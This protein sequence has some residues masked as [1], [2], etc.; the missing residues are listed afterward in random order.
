MKKKLVGIALFVFVAFM[1]QG[2]AYAY[3][4]T[5]L[6]NSFEDP[7]LA[8]NAWSQG[9]VLPGWSTSDDYWVGAIWGASGGAFGNTASDGNNAAWVQYGNYIWQTLTAQLLSNQQYTLT[10]D[11]GHR[12]GWL[13][14]PEILLYAYDPISL[15]FTTLV[16]SNIQAADLPADG[17]HK[18]YAI[19]Y[20]SGAVVPSGQLL[21]VKLMDLSGVWNSQPHFDNVRLTAI[22]GNSPTAATPEPGTIILMG[23]GFAGAALLRRKIRRGV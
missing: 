21:G 7:V 18:T 16:D 19:S 8:K 4:I 1:S 17:E 5:V 12:T 3:N 15:A 23:I 13:L 14:N 6:N 11:V 20:Q 9:T 2:H 22:S 10:V